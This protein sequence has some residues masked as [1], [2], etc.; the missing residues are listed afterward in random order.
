M[1]RYCKFYT[2]VDIDETFFHRIEIPTKFGFSGIAA[3][4]YFKE[5]PFPF[6]TNRQRNKPRSKKTIFPEK[7]LVWSCLSWSFYAQKSS[8]P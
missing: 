2:K 8:F 3:L 5:P 7:V 6:E 1:N 4:L